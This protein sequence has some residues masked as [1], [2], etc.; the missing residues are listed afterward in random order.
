M[1]TRDAYTVSVIR[2]DFSNHLGV[3]PVEAVPLLFYYKMRR[4]AIRESHGLVNPE[5]V[6]TNADINAL[7]A[8]L[9]N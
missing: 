5:Y 4:D 9:L 1:I 2:Q 7:I 8:R 6:N 3:P